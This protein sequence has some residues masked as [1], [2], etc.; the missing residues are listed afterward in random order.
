MEKR[1]SVRYSIRG[2][3][4]SLKRLGFSYKKN[5]LVPK[6]ADPEA[7][8]QFVR[9]FE[10]IRATLGP[11]D[12][13]YFLDVV[14][15]EHNAE[16]GYAWS[17]IGEPHRIPT[18]SGRQ[19]YNIL[20][21]YCAQ[22]HEHEFVLTTDNINQST[23]IA[24]LDRLHAKHPQADQLYVVLDNASYNRVIWVE[25]KALLGQIILKFLPP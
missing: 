2:M 13:L 24:L 12:R 8:E 19:R 14:H 15:L 4:S 25:A 3:H 21:A 6:K 23:M 18:N 7:Q 20:R 1:W 16:A 10:K 5:R 22:T 11:D 17:L 9:S